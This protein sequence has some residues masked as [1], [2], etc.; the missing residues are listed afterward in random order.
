MAAKTSWEFIQQVGL[1]TN[2]ETGEKNAVNITF[3]YNKNGNL[4]KLIVPLLTIVPIPYIAIDDVQINFK[5]NISAAS[6]STSENTSSTKMAAGIKGGAALNYGIF[7]IH[8]DFNANYSSKKDSKATEESKYSVEYTMDVSVHAGQSDM[9]A[10]LASVLNILQ[11]SITDADSEG[12]FSISP[13]NPIVDLSNLNHSAFSLDVKASIKDSEGL[14]VKNKAVTLSLPADLV[15]AYELSTPN[16]EEKTNNQ[17]QVVY[18]ITGTAK[19]ASVPASGN[20]VFTV[21]EEK[22]QEA[23]TGSVSLE[24]IGKYL[25]AEAESSAETT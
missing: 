3:Y 21:K 20:L 23:L 7:N 10:G 9:P 14:F 24:I 6:S 11:S 1:N 5:A 15:S 17:G 16:T 19:A 18:K 13:A 2:A 25:E 8:A 22:D 4:T 12:S